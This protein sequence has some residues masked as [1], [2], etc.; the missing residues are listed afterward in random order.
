MKIKL[1]VWKVTLL[2]SLFLTL[3]FNN[4]FWSKILG[5]Q[6]LSESPV[7]GISFFLILVAL[8]NILLTLI[9]FKP[10][11]KITVIVILLCSAS[12][13][14]FM[15]NYAIMIDKGMIRNIF[16]TDVHEATDLLSFKLIITLFLL[17]VIPAWLLYKTEINY[18]PFLK[19][20]AYKGLALSLSLAV[21]GGTLF[22]NYKELS[23]FG[24]NNREAR[25]LINPVNYIASIKSVV[26]KDLRNRNF[27]LQPIGKDARVVL[28]D[29]HTTGLNQRKPSLVVLVLGETARAMNFSLNGYQ[30]DTNPRLSK[31]D[32]IN[33]SDVTSCGTA[34]AVSVPCMFSKYTRNEF[35]F[36][37]GRQN[38]NLLDV[39][40]HAGYKVIWRDNN[41]GCQGTCDR[42]A[43]EHML[44]KAKSEFCKL[45]NC[46]DE[47]LLG[48]LQQIVDS[49]DVD[50]PTGDQLT[51][52]NA[53]IENQRGDRFI[54]LHTKGSH[55][56]TY[57]KRYPDEF[58]K[59]SPACK[60]NQ[61]L[62]CSRQEIV[63]AYDNTIL[64]TDYVL[65]K[66]INFLKEN[67]EKFDTAMVYISDHGESLG[68]N[69]LYLH[70][71]P[72]MLAPDYQKKVPFLLW[73]SEGYEKT[74][75]INKECLAGKSDKALSHDNLFSS[76]LGMLSIETEVHDN[77]LDIFSTCKKTKI[78]KR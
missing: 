58:E 60:T 47:V 9:S 76:I 42:I 68:E 16:A 75:G 17:A 19:G 51:K 23:F 39:I 2:I 33:F 34:T 46:F 53:V 59:F 37:K 11:F 49:S 4:A 62:D 27:K 72:Y 44:E 18:S 78:V 57:N 21:L 61:L 7:I 24:R 67:S 48:S 54:I 12:A 13:A 22:S 71:L 73:L 14:Y 64:Y 74:H 77:Q 6:P 8:F 20:L 3:F 15:D 36:D 40:T 38:E 10:I 70:G 56:P 65:D 5:L 50:T 26:S 1:P 66:S 29:F 43:Y 45:G 63:N 28:G 32:I 69:N 52:V 35:N 55:G 41:T 31:Q 30:R 25:H